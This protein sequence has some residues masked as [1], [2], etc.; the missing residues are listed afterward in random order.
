M[1]LEHVTWA[2]CLELG[3]VGH[4]VTAPT[5]SQLLHPGKRTLLVNNDKQLH[6]ECFLCKG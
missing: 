4:G 6:C 5:D 1:S 3:M 2:L